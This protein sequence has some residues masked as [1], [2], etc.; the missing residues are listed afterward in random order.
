MT[1]FARW[2]I[3][4]STPSDREESSTH[5]DTCRVLKH[6]REIL[7]PYGFKKG[8]LTVGDLSVASAEKRRRDI[9]LAVRKEAPNLQD[10]YV[11]RNLVPDAQTCESQEILKRM[12]QQHLIK[13]REIFEVKKQIFLNNA[14]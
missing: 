7:A 12:Q 5:P 13:A 1:P 9:E 2:D 10:L 14:E 6:S 4:R 8:K 3:N 11:G